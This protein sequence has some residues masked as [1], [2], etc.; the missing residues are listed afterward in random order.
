M[1]ALPG[2]VKSGN[3]MSVPMA[4]RG[5]PRNHMH[6]RP[7]PP[8]NSS[9]SMLPATKRATGANLAGTL[10]DGAVQEEAGRQGGNCARSTQLGGETTRIAKVC[11]STE[12]PNSRH[13]ILLR[14]SGYAW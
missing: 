13:Q 7:S 6:E 5:Q 2:G 8:Q 4:G 3:S 9:S 14:V 12:V 11:S 1:P 10:N